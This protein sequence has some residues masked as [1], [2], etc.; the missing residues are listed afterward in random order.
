MTPGLPVV[1]PQ[2]LKTIVEASPPA[3]HVILWINLLRGYLSRFRKK[4]FSLERDL[5]GFKNWFCSQKGN[6]L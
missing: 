1:I 2:I 4:L 3:L 6:K 5:L